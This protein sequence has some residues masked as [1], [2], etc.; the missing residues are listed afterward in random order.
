MKASKE[1]EKTMTFPLQEENHGAASPDPC[2]FVI[3]GATG[4][5]TNQRLIPGLFHLYQNGLLPHHFACVGF[6]RR[7]KDDAIFRKEVEEHLKT[8]KN[9]SLDEWLC[10]SEK[11]FYYKA[12][13]ENE[14]DYSSFQ[15]YLEKIDQKFHTQKN[16]IFYLAT[17]PKHFPFVIEKLAKS[18]CLSKKEE[19]TGW[20]RV[21][22]EKP[23]GRD[24]SSAKSLQEH[25][26]RYL[27]EEQIYRIDHYL[28]KETVQNILVFRF[29]NKIIDT[30][31]NRQQ[32]DHVQIT[33]AE[34]TGISTRG[35]F[36]EEQGI[37]RDVIQNHMMQLLALIAM[38]APKDLSAHSIRNEKVAVLR[39]LRP[40]TLDNFCTDISRGQYQSGFIH[41]KKAI[42]YREEN[43]IDPSS[44]RETYCSMKIHIDNKRWKNVP[45]YL[46]AGKR[47]PK[48]ITEIALVFKK[49]HKSFFKKKSDGNVISLRIQPN[50]GL[51][52]KINSKKPGQSMDMQPVQ[53]DFQYGSYFG[54][55]PPDAYER[56]I[57]DCM[58][59]DNSLFI[60]DDEVMA[61]WEFF[62]P[63]LS[64]FETHSAKD[65]P[66]Y[67]AGSW[68]PKCAEEMIHKDK[69][70]WRLL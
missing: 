62:D 51:S 7:E 63:V 4:N 46:R 44:N 24:L 12:E 36:F 25:I 11:L 29:A 8:T 66:N 37:I 43:D 27:S 2:I 64:Y 34:D 31:W 60:R 14:A 38:E 67:E 48:R 54:K 49:T 45:F 18:G 3:F 9:F 10:F 65:F 50:E 42:G 5:L 70:Q 56:L 32:I 58:A 23:F 53:M 47:L 21:I 30:V 57:Y 33:V 40:L 13:L 17:P 15:K 68:G 20:S 55:T 22:I 26:L 61:A 52:M 6:A 28:G 39:A 19:K 69:R 59:G 41:G 1:R 35:R 16:R